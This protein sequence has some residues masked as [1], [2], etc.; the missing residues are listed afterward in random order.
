DKFIGDAVMAVWGNMVTKGPE[1]DAQNAVAAA[2]A[3]KRSLA[4]LNEDWRKRGIRELALG[5]GVNFGDA[6]VG[7][8]GSTEKMELTVIGDAVNTASRLEGLTKRYHLDL[9]IG[10]AVAPLVRERFVLQTVDYVQVKGK[11]RPTEVFTVA[12]ERNPG[13]DA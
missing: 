4:R 8:M 9:L 3:M 7:N 11:T 10:E 6:V 2:L 12:G 13:L 1:T 5:I